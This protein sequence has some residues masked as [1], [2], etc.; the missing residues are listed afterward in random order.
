MYLC[1]MN[2]KAQHILEQVR[3]LYQKYG[4]KSI[5]MDDVASHLCI[6]K[7]TIYEFFSDKEDLVQHV[8]LAE[9]DRNCNFLD[10]IEQ[11]RLNAIEELFEVYK[12]ISM[13]FKEYNPSMVY[14]VRKY[15][16]DL[17]MKIRNVRRKRLYKTV[18]KNLNKGKREGLYRKELDAKIIAR[19]H[20]LRH[21]T[22]FDNDM[23]T[24]EEVGSFRMFHEVFVYHLHGI[25]SHE[26][27]IF[28]ESNF[29]RFREALG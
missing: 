27:R 8:L 9:H 13:V 5:T 4:I 10:T 17:F 2:P 7:K 19:L 12:M 26:G 1:S 29:A 23:F 25:L 24:Q 20:V 15:Y 6:S 22:L 21:E 28:F 18:Y 11:Q 14:D 3:I 16:P